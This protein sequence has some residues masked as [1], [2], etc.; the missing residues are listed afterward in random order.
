[1]FA[2]TFCA[3]PI[4]C[5]DQP[6]VLAA[7]SKPPIPDR[8]PEQPSQQVPPIVAEA[9]PG[10]LG[11]NFS[12]EV[13]K[14]RA[15][16][17]EYILGKGAELFGDYPNL[18]FAADSAEDASAE[19]GKSKPGTASALD[20]LPGSSGE[21]GGEET[22]VVDGNT[23]GLFVPVELP[24][25]AGRDPLGHFYTSLREL[26]QGDDPDNKVRVMVYGASHTA[27][28]VYVG[29]L[30]A[31]LQHRFGDGGLGYVA[32]ARTNRW[33]RLH[34]FLVE[35]SKGWTVEHAQRRNARPDGYYGLLGASTMTTKL[36]DSS[37]VTP[38][39]GRFT[40]TTGQTTYDLM[41]LAQPKGGAFE[42]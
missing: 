10:A 13:L 33:Y 32:L 42:V 1:M 15:S 20:S 2:A 7:S 30:R 28:D 22:P 35:S 6:A 12:P 16:A 5:C 23:L 11:P 27:A 37:R 19:N 4:G 17:Q 39:K 9:Q 38:R 3:G 41:Y 31:Y 40:P 36:R 8:A 29:Y 18:V 34:A 24:K 25:E 14:A 21:T 26:R